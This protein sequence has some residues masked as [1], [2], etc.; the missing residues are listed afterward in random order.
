MLIIFIMN[1]IL[2]NFIAWTV[3]STYCSINTIVKNISYE[4]DIY[5]D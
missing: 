2:Q 3:L 5:E 1:M 4:M